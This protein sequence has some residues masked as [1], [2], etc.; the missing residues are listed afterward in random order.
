MALEME[1]RLQIPVRHVHYEDY[2]E[3]LNSTLLGIIEFLNMTDE[4]R[5]PPPSFAAGKNYE[6]VSPVLLFC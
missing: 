1:R 6:H 3:S 2:Q 5:A 4:V